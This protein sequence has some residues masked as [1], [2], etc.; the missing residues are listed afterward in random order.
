MELTQSKGQKP[1]GELGS[2][3]EGHEEER[4]A[5]EERTSILCPECEENVSDI[6]MKT[7]GYVLG[8]F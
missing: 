1:K 7:K 3:E 5:K 6:K 8:K 4:K 2:L